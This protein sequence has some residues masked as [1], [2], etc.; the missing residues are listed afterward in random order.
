MTLKPGD[1]PW[2]PED[3][4]DYL[5]V[6]RRQ[7]HPPR[8]REEFLNLQVLLLDDLWSEADPRLRE[9]ANY[10]LQHNLNQ[11]V[12][13]G[14]PPLL[15]HDQQTCRNLLL[16]PLEEGSHQQ[17][18]VL[19]LPAKLKLPPMSPEESLLEAKGLDLESFLDRLL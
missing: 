10:R 7:Q 11:A 2:A 6:L 17:E 13:L 3:S 5:C 15:F 16:N 19:D 4:P 8:N 9:Q 1:R 14:L 18:W 12:L